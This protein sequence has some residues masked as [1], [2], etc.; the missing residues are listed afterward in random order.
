MRPPLFPSAMAP[1]ISMQYIC[2]PCT[3]V[4]RYLRQFTSHRSLTTAAQLPSASI[5]GPVSPLSS[6]RFN[7]ST[8]TPTQAPIPLRTVLSLSGSTAPKFLQGLLTTNI[9]LDFPSTPTAADAHY[10]SLLT[11]Q[12]RVIADVFVYPVHKSV[13]TVTGTEGEPTYLI[14]CAG[15]IAKDLERHLR[16]YMLRAKLQLKQVN[17]EWD[18][19]VSWGTGADLFTRFLV[20][21]EVQLPPELLHPAE[22]DPNLGIDAYHLRRYVHGVPEGPTEI[23]SSSALPHEYNLDRMGGIDFRKGCYVGQE[24]TVRTEHRGVVRKRAVVLRLDEDVQGAPP[25]VG[26]DIV[27]VGRWAEE[28]GDSG[29]VVR[30]RGGRG[31][32]GRWIGG[33]GRVGLGVVRLEEVFFGLRGREEEGRQSEEVGE[34]NQ[35]EERRRHGMWSGTSS[36]SQGDGES[37][38]K[39]EWSVGNGG[40]ETAQEGEEKNAVGLRAWMPGWHFLRRR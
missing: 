38:L 11:P 34:E 14:E 25:P 10:S 32:V 23:P 15:A 6:A 27:K 24:L 20:P 12:G 28:S 39:M 30:R 16:R 1:A 33:L 9:P 3:S 5:P 19:W 36:G 18:V 8:P 26:A 4:L 7:L 21:R 29:V 35:M 31:G 37:G 17:D 40:G 13:H 22:S 2:P